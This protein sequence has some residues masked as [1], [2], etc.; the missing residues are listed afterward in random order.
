ML[1]AAGEVDRYIFGFEESY[2]Y[3]AGAHVRDKD[4]VVASMLICEMARWY[5]AK[6]MD[7][8]DAINALYEKYGYYKSG[9]ISVNYPGAEGAAKMAAITAG[10][11][12]EQPA[13]IAG[14][15]VERF[16]D[17]KPGAAMPICGGRG[18]VAEQMMPG[19]DVLE[20]RLEGGN[21]LMI[22]PSGTEPKIKA[23]LFSRGAT[24][25]EA[26]AILADLEA[27]ARE[28]LFW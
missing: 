10:L 27:A 4:A 21:K 12:A 23:Y 6:G 24:K 5:R 16:V 9:L 20:F 14:L 1:E 8:V 13:E 11:R 26:D 22:R 28:L 19:A 18:D 17:Y 25:E 15:K 2:G 3:L 7:L